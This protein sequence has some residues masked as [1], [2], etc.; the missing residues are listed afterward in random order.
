ME[1]SVHNSHI[2]FKEKTEST[3]KLLDFQISLIKALCRQPLCD[4]VFSDDSDDD[5][6]PPKT[7]KHD[8]AS[9]LKGGFNSHHICT[10]PSTGTK[11]IHKGNA[12]Y[13]QKM[14]DEKIQDIFVKNVKL[15]FV[16]NHAWESNTRKNICEFV[17]K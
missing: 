1:I 15:R 7:P 3:M 8:P 16:T 11:N 4:S 17:N 13:A 6:L 9:R 14:E 5:A 10:L 2:L 12:D